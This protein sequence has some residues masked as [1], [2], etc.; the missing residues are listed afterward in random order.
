MDAAG[1]MKEIPDATVQTLDGVERVATIVIR[2]ARE[3]LTQTSI[4]LC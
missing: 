3:W 1:I 2:T 4:K